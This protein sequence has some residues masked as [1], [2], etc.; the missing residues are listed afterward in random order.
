[1]S[2]RRPHVAHLAA[3]TA[4]VTA[5]VLAGA[6]EIGAGPV[7]PAGNGPVGSHEAARP[8]RS[9]ATAGETV[10]PLRVEDADIV[11]ALDDLGAE[12]RSQLGEVERA[13]AALDEARAE[14]GAAEERIARTEDRIDELV[15]ASDEVVVDAFVN[16]PSDDGLEALAADSLSETTVKRSILDRQ[17]TSSAHILDALDAARADLGEQRQAREEAASTAASRAGEAEAR[18]TDLEAAMSQQATLVVAVEA[19][20]DRGLAEAEALARV[21]PAAAE[22]LRA[23]ETDLVRAL[24]G[25]REAEEQRRAQA[26]LRA[27]QAEE[28]RR[29]RER[30]AQAPPDLGPPTGGLGRAACPGGGEITVD[31]SLAGNLQSLLDAAAADGVSLC[32][33]GFRD[34]QE[35]VELR[36]QNCGTSSYAVYQAPSS[37][38]SPPTARPGTSNH[39]R[40]LAVDFRC[41]GGSLGRSSSCFSWLSANA[42][43][44]GLHNLPSEPWHWSTDGS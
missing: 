8:L 22:R 38:C 9:R 20:I 3:L 34:P 43:G 32:G 19:R 29:A 2:T 25:I 18:L 30:A 13:R 5:G 40:G 26:A 42:S 28:R 21:D 14:V 37:S 15:V 24:R 27:A 10:D 1:M 16:P 36:R 44:Y 7:G 17:A 11:G 39:E 31:S 6:V 4:V 12:V 35:Q 41:D 33:A 23:R